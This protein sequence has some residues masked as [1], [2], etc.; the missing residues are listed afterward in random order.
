MN[1]GFFGLNGVTRKSLIFLVLLGILMH[2]FI[3]T[4]SKNLGPL[5]PKFDKWRY[6]CLNKCKTAKCENATMKF[7]GANYF[8][9]KDEKK[10]GTKMDHR[11]CAFTIWELTHFLF[12]IFL[13]LYYNIYISVGTSVFFEMYEH[14][15]YDCGSVLDLGWNFAGF[16][17]GF[18]LRAI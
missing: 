4:L 2:Y 17:T 8:D 16:V 14:Y 12:H 7:R 13:G 15:M 6:W 3:F 5:Q 10:K 18:A 11:G 1:R 9:D